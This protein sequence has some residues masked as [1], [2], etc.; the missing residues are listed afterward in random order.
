MVYST[1]KITCT[2]GG[3]IVSS[4]TEQANA[5]VAKSSAYPLSVTFLAKEGEQVIEN[6]AF[7]G[8]YYKVTVKQLRDD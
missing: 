4:T 8:G 3:K 7:P 6:R 5:I 1:F 2:V